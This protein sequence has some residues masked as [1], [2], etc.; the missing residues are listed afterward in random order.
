MSASPSS[1]AAPHRVGYFGPP[2]TNTHAAALLLFGPDAEYAPFPSIALVFDAVATGRVQSGVVPVENST[3]GVVRE[4]IDCLINKSPVIDGELDMEIR[5]CLLAPPGLEPTQAK[6]ILSHPQA[7]AQCRIW[8]DEHYPLIPRLAAASTAAA[9]RDARER[10]DVL[11]IASSLAAATEGLTVIASGVADRKHNTTR[12]VSLRLEDAPPTGRDKTSLVFTTHHERGAL[13]RILGILDD[14]GV[15]LT[16]I[17]SRPLPHQLW[18]YAFVV[19]VEGHRRDPAVAQA[20]A[21]LQKI[22]A[23]IKVL[24]SYP[25]ASSGAAARL[26]S[27]STIPP[28]AS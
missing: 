14:A 28:S 5:H 25:A 26:P 1:S 3:E 8:L 13:R 24:G 9:A 4:T 19:D 15:N 23:L 18:E 20:L 21:D 12:F 17:E 7:L 27:E 2:A 6:A 16:R 11:A 10:G 22:G